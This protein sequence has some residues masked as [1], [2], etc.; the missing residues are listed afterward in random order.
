M[1]KSSTADPNRF[2]LFIDTGGFIAVMNDRDL[3]HLL[4]MAA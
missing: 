4:D 2:D 1:R 3:A